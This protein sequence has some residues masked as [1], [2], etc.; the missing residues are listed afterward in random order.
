MNDKATI[1]LAA[2]VPHKPWQWNAR[3]LPGPGLAVRV[4]GDVTE[5]DALD[6]LRAVDE[7]FIQTI[8]EWGLYDRIWQ[9]FA[10]FLPVRCARRSTRPQQSWLAVLGG[11]ACCIGRVCSGR[12]R[13]GKMCCKTHI[14]G[15]S[16]EPGSI[17]L[18]RKARDT[19]REQRKT[20]AETLLTDCKLV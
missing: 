14:F 16:E 2:T 13:S 10:V 1:K 9:A 18:A 3:P 4:L 8:R 17:L 20:C 12:V 6:V 11:C 19:V 15:S 7:V 5:G